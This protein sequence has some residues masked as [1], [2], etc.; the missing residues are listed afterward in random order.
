MRQEPA[1]S[2][3]TAVKG[4]R[5][6]PMLPHLVRIHRVVALAVHHLHPAHVDNRLDDETTASH[7]LDVGVLRRRGKVNCRPAEAAAAQTEACLQ[8]ALPGLW[9]GLVVQLQELSARLG[10]G[11]HVLSLRAG[12]DPVGLEHELEPSL[13]LRR[14]MLF[15]LLMAMRRAQLAQGQV[16]TL[17]GAA[18]VVLLHQRGVGFDGVG[19][20]A[21]PSGVAEQC[22][23]GGRTGD[24]RNAPRRHGL[25]P[26][27]PNVWCFS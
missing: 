11:A 25:Q 12:A 5:V 16:A 9:G 23:R 13:R 24:R 4:E 21:R 3:A 15:C 17:F 6:P 14:S 7:C 20:A 2:E 18:S 8:D 10:V 22:G 27:L 26:R 1:L 19:R